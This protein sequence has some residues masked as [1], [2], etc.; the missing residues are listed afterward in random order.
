MTG[1]GVRGT[2]ISD[3]YLPVHYGTINLVHYLCRSERIV[4][5]SMVQT[6]RPRTFC[7]W[8]GRWVRRWDRWTGGWWCWPRGE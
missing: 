5:V 4:S 1:D 2:A 6:G 8:A 7:T 3:P